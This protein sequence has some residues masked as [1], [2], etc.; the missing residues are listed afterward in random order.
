MKTKFS[1]ERLLKR[2]NSQERRMSSVRFA[3][4]E[5]GHLFLAFGAG[6]CF[7]NDP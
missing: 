2:L 1:T 5:S 4:A 6:W 3:A 7:H